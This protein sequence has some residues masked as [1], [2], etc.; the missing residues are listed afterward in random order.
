MRWAG[1]VAAIGKNDK[2]KQTSQKKK[3][4]TNTKV[5]LTK[6]DMEGGLNSSDF[7]QGSAAGCCERSNKPL[8]A[9]PGR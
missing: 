5:V 9:R 1:Y 3:N 6:C 8:H 2:L 7:G 4:T